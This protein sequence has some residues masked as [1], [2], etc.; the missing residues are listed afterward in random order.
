MFGYENS[1][2][3][4]NLRKMQEYQKHIR[5]NNDNTLTWCEEHI[6][7]DWVFTDVE[8]ALLVVEQGGRLQICP[9]CKEKIIEIL[10]QSE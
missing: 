1:Y 10:N 8:H 3:N 9:K 6:V 7:W 4:L 2:R 5:K